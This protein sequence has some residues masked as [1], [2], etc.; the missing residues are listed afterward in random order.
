MDR[1]QVLGRA[2]LTAIIDGTVLQ[3]CIGSAAIMAEQCAHLLHTAS[4]P[5]IALHVV[6]EGTN[7]GL[8]ARSTLP[9]GAE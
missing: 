6:A 7:V 1:Q 2:Y 4:R 3:R 9:R 5:N 8:W